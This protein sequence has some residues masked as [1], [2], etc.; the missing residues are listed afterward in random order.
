MGIGQLRTGKLLFGGHASKSLH[1]AK[2]PMANCQAT[3]VESGVYRQFQC[4]IL[5]MD[6]FVVKG[7]IFHCSSQPERNLFS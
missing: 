1:M 3:F 6:S 7:I 2:C 5:L 4:L